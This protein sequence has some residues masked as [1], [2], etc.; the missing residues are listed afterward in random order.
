M[1]SRSRARAEDLADVLHR[2]RH[3]RQLLERGAGRRGDDPGER[4]LPA[5]R[6]PVEDRRSGRGPRRSRAAAPIP[7][8]ARAP[9]RRTRRASAAAAA[10][11]AAP[12]RRPGGRLRRRRGRPRAEVCSAAWR[13]T[14]LRGEVADLLRPADPCRH[15]E[16]A[17]QRDAPRPSCCA[18]TSRRTA[19]PAS[20]TPACPSARTSSR[21]SAAA[22]TGRRSCCSRHTDIVLADPAEWAVPPWS[23]ELRDGEVWGRGALDM[24]GQVAASAVAIAS[25]AR[26]GFEPAGDLDLRRRPPTRRSATASGSRGSARSTP[27]R[28]AATTRSTRAAATGSSSAAASSTSASTAEKMSAPFL[29]PRARPLRPRVDAG[30]RRQRAR[31]GGAADRAARRVPARAAGSQP[32]VEAFLRAVLG[33]VPPAGA[34]LERGARR[35]TRSRR[36]AASSRCSR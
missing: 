4:R 25:L 6:R 28:F 23:G 34:A 27:T 36:G 2:R 7:R 33:D 12:A 13:T 31:Q 11:R 30:D 3:R 19:S 18:A 32:E 9:G 14:T 29:P 21:G 35:A 26:E 24:K 1:P 10:A 22:A 5:P 20:C 15:D 16:S 17:R 8:R